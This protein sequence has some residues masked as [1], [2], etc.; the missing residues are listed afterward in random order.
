MQGDNNNNNNNN[1]DGPVLY[2][3]ARMMKPVVAQSHRALSAPMHPLKDSDP[4]FLLDD[5]GVSVRVCVRARVC[6]GGWVCAC[7]HVR[8]CVHVRMCACV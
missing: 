8:W 4:A 6:V 2:A 5:L 7:A 1:N 3:H